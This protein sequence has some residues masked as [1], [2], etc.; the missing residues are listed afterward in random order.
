MEVVRLSARRGEGMDQFLALLERQLAE[1]RAA[2]VA[3]SAS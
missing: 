2:R 3:G 1:T